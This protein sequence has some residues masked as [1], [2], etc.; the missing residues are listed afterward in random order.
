MNSFV[1]LILPKAR[2]RRYLHFGAI[3]GSSRLQKRYN[4]LDGVGKKWFYT[5]WRF[6]GWFCGRF[7]AKIYSKCRSRRDL[8]LGRT[9]KIKKRLTNTKTLK[10]VYSG[11]S[12]WILSTGQYWSSRLVGL[13]AWWLGGFLGVLW[14]LPRGLGI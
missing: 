6:W 7:G 14:R 2:S 4:K 1:D 11:Y 3:F 12:A 10:L 5:A 8:Y 13:V 9:N